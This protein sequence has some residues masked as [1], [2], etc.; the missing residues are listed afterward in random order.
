MK[1]NRLEVLKQLNREA[2]RIMTL[3]Q[4][5]KAYCKAGDSVD[6]RFILE[7]L[8]ARSDAVVQANTMITLNLAGNTKEFIEYVMTNYDRINTS[9]TKTEPITEEQKEDL[10]KAFDAIESIL[11]L[12][13]GK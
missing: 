1:D 7:H 10:S 2:D 12:L 8:I 5:I 6:A 9:E 11:R 3:M 13:G 4:Y